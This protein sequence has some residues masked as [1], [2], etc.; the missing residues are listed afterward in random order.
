MP[1]YPRFAIYFTPRREDALCRLGASTLGYD[2][3]GGEALPFPDPLAAACADW[4]E[5][6]EEP[7]KYGF[8]ATL[9]AP[10]ALAAGRD[11][12]QLL[13]ACR[14]FA[15][16]PR[17]LAAITPVVRPISDF[18]A[19]VPRDDAP[20][21]SAFAQACVEAFDAFRAPLTD[22]D[23]ARRNPAQLTP[24][25]RANLEQWGYPYVEDDFRFHMTLA[26]RIATARRDT[27]VG[28]LREQFAAFETRPLLIDRI[29]VFRQD[30]PAARFRVVAS[31][32]LRATAGVG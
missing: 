23:R 22:N 21:L 9:K 30:A 2:A 1:S 3:F 14:R 32:P 27:I 8:H 5:L 28:L 25:Q 31:Y 17:D 18:V 19:L 11:Q 4:R 24:R 20:D 12:Q 16:T 7:R 6:T 13:E 26:G 29:S 10:F 15:E